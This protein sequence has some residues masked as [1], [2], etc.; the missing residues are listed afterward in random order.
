VQIKYEARFEKD[1]RKIQDSN[2]L[3]R[4]KEFINIIK[5]AES[6]FDVPQIKKLKGY[7]SFYRIKIGNYR[8][9]FEVV[10]EILI[11]TRILHRKDIYRYFP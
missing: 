2:L 9:G 4:I 1:L 8:I 11:F 7:N 6:I 5:K 3:K 10:S